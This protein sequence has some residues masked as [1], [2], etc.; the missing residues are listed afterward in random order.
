MVRVFSATTRASTPSGT[1]PDGW[2][3]ISTVRMPWRTRALARSVAPV[4]SSAMAPRTADMACSRVAFLYPD[5]S[6]NGST[7]GRAVH[8]NPRE[9]HEMPRFAANLSWLFLEHDFLD[10]FH[11]AA[12]AGLRAV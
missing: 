2:P 9:E 11:A 5:G 7:P 8:S 10:R 6:T 1:G 3:S 4:K 12:D